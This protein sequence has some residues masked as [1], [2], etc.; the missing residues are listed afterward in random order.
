MIDE[1]SDREV[2]AVA[3]WQMKEQDEY[4]GC[5]ASGKAYLGSQL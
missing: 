5:P 2:D 3:W 4:T 1:N